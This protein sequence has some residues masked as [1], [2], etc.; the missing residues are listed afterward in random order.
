M[1]ILDAPVRL[2]NNQYIHHGKSKDKLQDYTL[3]LLA[4]FMAQPCRN[5]HYENN[6]EYAVDLWNMNNAKVYDYRSEDLEAEKRRKKQ[7]WRACEKAIAELQGFDISDF[8]DY[9]R[10]QDEKEQQ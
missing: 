8:D 9:Y 5:P 3:L 10:E 4:D 1:G 2:D 6:Y 7:Q